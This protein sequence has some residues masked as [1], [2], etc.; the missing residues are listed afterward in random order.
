MSDWISA[1]HSL[2]LQR[3]SVC[4]C[5]VKF[6]IR[7]LPSTMPSSSRL[8]AFRQAFN[9]GS[10]APSEAPQPM[11]IK[12]KNPKKAWAHWRQL[13]DKV[14][15][16]QHLIGCEESVNLW[17]PQEAEGV[18]VDLTKASPEQL[19]EHIKTAPLMKSLQSKVECRFKLEE[20]NH[21]KEFL[22]R[23]GNQWRTWV[24]CKGCNSR[25]AATQSRPVS[26]K[27]KGKSSPEDGSADQVR[28]LKEDLERMMSREFV[29]KKEADQAQMRMRRELEKQH[30]QGVKEEVRKAQARLRTEMEDHFR[31]RV[32]EE[33]WTLRKLKE[34][35]QIYNIAMK[36]YGQ[37]MEPK[38]NECPDYF[39]TEMYLYCQEKFK[40][41]EE[42]RELQDCQ[43]ELEMLAWTQVDEEPY[44]SAAAS[45]ARRKVRKESKSRS[46]SGPRKAHG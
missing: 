42:I 15:A 26:S 45:A 22:V 39:D 41:R 25:W 6:A 27:K 1:Q 8:A 44:S 37:R 20:C 32:K 7:S 11:D 2:R 34:E 14:F 35:V 33:Q 5:P 21:G 40:Y 17:L 9:R 31:H 23:G 4:A 29:D 28:K 36:E 19:A 18:D 13:L 12:T 24:I 16:L 46:T 43:D 38:Y 10:A 3:V 30:S